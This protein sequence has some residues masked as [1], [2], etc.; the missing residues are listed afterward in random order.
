MDNVVT[1]M[2]TKFVTFRSFLKI[3]MLFRIVKNIE[4]I[5]IDSEKPK[6]SIDMKKKE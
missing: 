5:H 4:K 6:N 3:P 2:Y 1:K